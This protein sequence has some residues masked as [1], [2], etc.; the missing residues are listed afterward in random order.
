M[1]DLKNAHGDK[2]LEILKGIGG[3]DTLVESA[4]EELAQYA[5][6]V[7]A[8]LEQEYQKKIGR[9][10]QIC[11]EEVAKERTT[12]AKRVKTFLE[13]KAASMEQAATRARAIEES[14]SAARLKKAKAILEG[15]EVN[16]TGVTSQQLQDANKKN[17]RL[18]KA[19]ASL[20]E[21]RNLAVQKANT[22]NEIAAK[23]LQR[24]RV[25]ET[26][27]TESVKP[28][29]KPL[30]EGY[31]ANH[32]LPFPKAGKCAKCPGD[33]APEVKDEKVEEAKA[34][35][36]RLD[37]GRQVAAESHSTRRTMVE[38]QTRNSAR[39]VTEISK[40]AETIE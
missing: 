1:A 2:F 34:P 14:E 20:K 3:N 21:E 5:A 6:T 23:A 25:L 36:T 9:A 37:A 30:E 31:C 38:S 27:V 28:E 8:G 32:K 17:M 33:K 24:S 16:E 18:E 10:K 22:A 15:V 35:E 4:K 7:R 29:T 19:M 11:V 40:I 39:P 13:S 12:L 26:K